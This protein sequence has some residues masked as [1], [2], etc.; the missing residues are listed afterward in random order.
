MTLRLFSSSFL[1]CNE[2]IVS[3]RECVRSPLDLIYVL[4]ETFMLHSLDIS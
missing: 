2:L 4:E 1:D 3:F